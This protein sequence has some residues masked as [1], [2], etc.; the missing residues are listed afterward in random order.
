MRKTMGPEATRIVELCSTPP[1]PA[2]Q[3]SRNSAGVANRGDDES[4]KSENDSRRNEL[5]AQRRTQRQVMRH[6][7]D[8]GSCLDADDEC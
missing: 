4:L 6:Q 3:Q 2:R 7:T 8:G 1:P 5:G